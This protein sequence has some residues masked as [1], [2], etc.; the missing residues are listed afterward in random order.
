MFIAQPHM[1]SEVRVRLFFLCLMI[2]TMIAVS[3]AL[4]TTPRLLANVLSVFVCFGLVYQALVVRPKTG[5]FGGLVWWNTLRWV[6]I[7]LWG[8]AAG[9]FLTQ[10]SSSIA[11]VPLFIDVAVSGIAGLFHY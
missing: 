8:L 6:H 11:S 9:L 2:R 5:F 10:H 3:F 4:A 7:I 1:N